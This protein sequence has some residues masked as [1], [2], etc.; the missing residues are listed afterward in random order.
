MADA[1]SKAEVVLVSLSQKYK[2]S[3]ACRTGELSIRFQMDLVYS[4]T[5]SNKTCSQLL[6]KT[7]IDQRFM[8]ND[9]FFSELEYARSMGR[10]I[11]PL[12]IQAR[13][14]PDGWLAEVSSSNQ[15][16]LY[17]QNCLNV[18]VLHT[19]IFYSTPG[20]WKQFNIRFHK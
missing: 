7:L 11:I 3:P 10:P 16:K 9:F 13:Y 12:K 2:D 6:T 17:N 20:R 18:W 5:L 4:C 1:V 19:T 15:I 8:R 14:N